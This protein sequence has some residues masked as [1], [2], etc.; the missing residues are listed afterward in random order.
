MSPPH[1]CVRGYS[2]GSACAPAIAASRTTQHL[3]R[4]V[5]VINDGVHVGDIFSPVGAAELE[6]NLISP[7]P[8][9]F[10]PGTEQFPTTERKPREA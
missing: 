10:T 1:A 9:M 8:G 4:T 7:Y 2:A 6:L 3:A 5:A